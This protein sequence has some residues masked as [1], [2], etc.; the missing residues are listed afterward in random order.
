MGVRQTGLRFLNVR[1]SPSFPP[2]A[3]SPSWSAE[4][5]KRKG[6]LLSWFEL[7]KT[8]QGQSPAW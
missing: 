8:Q 1:S 7:S 6:T 4:C 2:E 3:V 5:Q